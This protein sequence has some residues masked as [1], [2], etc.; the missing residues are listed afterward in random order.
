LLGDAGDGAVAGAGDELGF[1]GAAGLAVPPVNPSKNSSKNSHV[2]ILRMAAIV[3]PVSY[4][5]A[6]KLP[7]ERVGKRLIV[8]FLRTN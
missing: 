4:S 1:W 5:L 7:M 3:S 2:L 8:R 6:G